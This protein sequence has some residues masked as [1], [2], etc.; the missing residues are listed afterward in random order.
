MVGSP[1][2]VVGGEVTEMV[3]QVVSIV[4]VALAALFAALA[5]R[6]SRQEQRRSAA[7]VTAL[8]NAIDGV[9]PQPAGGGV[10]SVGGVGAIQP[11]FL[12]HQRAAV[13]SRLL[14]LAIGFAMAVAV[15]IA[16]ATPGTSH[17]PSSASPAAADAS[18]ELLSM[19]PEREGN[20][21]TVTGLVRNGGTGPAQR[22]I[23]V[24]FTFDRD[25]TFVA[26]GRAPLEFVSLAPGDES[27]FRVSVPNVAGVDRYRVSFR[28]EAGVVRHI[29]R[30]QPLL[31]SK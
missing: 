14:K 5:W 24:I 21:L 19:K 28:T 27:P 31:A 30:R 16:V 7:R 12:T 18:L 4:S 25:G 20:T 26:S 13:G 10:G 11:E 6:L 22:L 2:L 9:S 3:L 8:A 23:A 29:D 15:I 17:R 1:G